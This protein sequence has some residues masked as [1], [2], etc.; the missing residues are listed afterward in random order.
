MGT[1]QYTENKLIYINQNTSKALNKSTVK[2]SMSLNQVF[3]IVLSKPII[4]I[5]Q[6]II[7]K[8]IDNINQNA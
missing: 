1:N 5:I 2:P 6:N 8:T 7:T 3:S 4:K